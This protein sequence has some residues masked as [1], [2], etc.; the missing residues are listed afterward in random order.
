MSHQH[1]KLGPRDKNSIFIRYSE[2][3]K[4]YVFIDEQF[5][6]KFESR[7]VIFLENE[8]PRKDEIVQDFFSI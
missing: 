6:T 5:V 8:F 7:D 2:H 4:G 3:S 1:D